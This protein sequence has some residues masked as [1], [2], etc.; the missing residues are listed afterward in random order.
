MEGEERWV[1]VK[2]GVNENALLAR[3]ADKGKAY[4]P[5]SRPPVDTSLPLEEKPIGGLGIHL[6]RQMM[7]EL[8]YARE[9]Q[10]NV[11]RMTKS[12]HQSATNGH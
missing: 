3:I 4:N 9:G 2:L 10:V 12:Y 7:D 5:L 8:T 1:S 6:M 11:L